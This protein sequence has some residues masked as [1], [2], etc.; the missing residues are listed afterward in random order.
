VR[1][2]NVA[3]NT[4]VTRRKPDDL[5]AVAESAVQAFALTE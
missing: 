4:L 2:E 1:H 3:P 5:E